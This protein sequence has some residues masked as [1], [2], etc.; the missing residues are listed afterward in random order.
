MAQDPLHLL[1]IEPRFP[2]RLGAVA[3][4]LVRRRGYRCQFYCT[5]ADS[6]DYW[7]PSVG[8]GLEIV[9]FKVGGVARKD[10]VEWSRHLER[11]ICYAYGCWE[12]LHMRQPRPVELVLGR[13]GGLG[14]TLFVPVFLPGVPVV[15]QFDYFYHPHAHDVAA[16]GG[17][18]TPVEYFCWRRTAC[19][20]DLLELENGVHAWATTNW[21]RDLY[22]REYHDA[23]FVLHDGID[24]RRFGPRTRRERAIAGRAIGPEVRVVTFVARSLDRVRGFDRLVELGNRLTRA[25]ADVLLVVVGSPVAQRGLDVWSYGQDYRAALLARQPLHDPGRWWFLDT[26]SPPVV[27]EVLA[28]SDLHVYPSREYPVSRSLLEAFAAG[29]TVLAWDSAPLREITAQG[30]VALAAS[31]DDPDQPLRLAGAALDDPAAHR[32]LGEAAAE[33]VRARYAQDVTL[34]RLAQHFDRLLSVRCG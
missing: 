11:G 1:C 10:S 33:L 22:P 18:E 24:T 29:C 3:D 14:S 23:F 4:W 28:A 32:P 26:V 2:G 7:P 12:V 25:R 20:M 34:P 15:Q 30:Q 16:E 13:S 5:A 31:P 19:A 27:A 8:R 17:P 21:Q 6:Q 9:P